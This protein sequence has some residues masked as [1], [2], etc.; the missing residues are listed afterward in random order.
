[1]K[2]VPR[3]LRN[4]RDRP[5]AKC[6]RLWTIRA[7]DLHRGRTVDNVDQLVAGDMGFPMTFP[8][9]LGDEQAAVAVGR[10]SCAAALSIRH[11]RLRRPPGEDRELRELAL[12]GGDRPAVDKTRK[13][14][15]QWTL[16]WRRQSRAN[17][18]QPNSLLY[19][20]NTGNFIGTLASGTRIW[21]LNPHYNQRLPSKFPTQRNRELNGPHQGIK[22]A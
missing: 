5:G 18:S 20:E 8:G 14:G 13:L 9:E 11:G 16:R 15:S 1:M 19:R 12:S 7:H 6:E 4:D 10:Q 2:A 3:A 22:S 21:C 17:S